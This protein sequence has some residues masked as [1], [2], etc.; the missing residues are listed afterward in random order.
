MKE[1]QSTYAFTLEDHFVVIP[2]FLSDEEQID[3]S[4]ESQ[5]KI[6]RLCQKQYDEGHYDN[7][8][9]GYKECSASSLSSNPII[10]RS[11][12]FISRLLS[13]EF[14]WLPPHLLDMRK[15]DSYILPHTD[16]LNASGRVVAGLCLESDT[17]M[18]FTHTQNE[19]LKF[20]VLLPKG[21]LYVQWYD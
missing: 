16:N 7:V 6:A 19:M 17:V 8:I 3:L 2:S 18:T 4:K 9:K 13:D 11:T 12:I 10:N 14:K 20:K 1:L 15:N 5:Y 21:C